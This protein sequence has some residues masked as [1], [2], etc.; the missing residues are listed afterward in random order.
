MIRRDARFERGENEDLL[1]AAN[2]KNRS[3]AIA[4]IKILLSI[5]SNACGNS[6]AFGISTRGAIRSYAINRAVIAGRDIHLPLAIEGDGSCIH[7]LFDE[8]FYRIV[9]VDLE[10]RYGNL[11][12]A[13][14]RKSHIDVALGI[15]CRAGNWMQ[16]FRNKDTNFYL[17]RIAHV[18]VGGNHHGSGGRAFGNSSNH[19]RI[20]THDHRSLH[21]AELDAGTLELLRA[22]SRTGD[23]YFAPGQRERGDH[24]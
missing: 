22:Q 6:H 2:L 15:E 17:L 16:I 4:H 23:A 11:L 8:G 12:P 3:A 20:R 7:H 19:E 18:A 10:N 5:K 1:V 9:R 21:V 24:S 14:P 13:R